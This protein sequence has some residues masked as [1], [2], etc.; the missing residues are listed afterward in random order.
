[1]STIGQVN[2][3]STAQEAESIGTATLQLD[4]NDMR[5]NGDLLTGEALL[6]SEGK[7]EKVYFYYTIETEEE[8]FNWEQQRFPQR[9]VATVRWRSR[10]LSGICTNLILKII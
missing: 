9:V 5:I 2:L 1:M 4:P 6:Q 8:K 3:S 10:K 7:E